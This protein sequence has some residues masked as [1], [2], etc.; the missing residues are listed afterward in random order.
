VEARIDGFPFVPPFEDIGDVFWIC[1]EITF[2]FASEL[3]WCR[4]DEGR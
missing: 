4:R 3:S 2:E 1:A